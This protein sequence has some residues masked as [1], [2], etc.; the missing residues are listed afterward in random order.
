MLG[1]SY[2]ISWAACARG[3]FRAAM[4]AGGAAGHAAGHVASAPPARR[5]R[6]S[7]FKHSHRV[8]AGPPAT[9]IQPGFMPDLIVGESEVVWMLQSVDT[10]AATRLSCWRVSAGRVRPRRCSDRGGSWSPTPHMVRAAS[11]LQRFL[12]S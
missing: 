3:P 8:P 10:L 5:G 4:A 6:A 9:K 11:A 1:P 12:A 7:G 2:C